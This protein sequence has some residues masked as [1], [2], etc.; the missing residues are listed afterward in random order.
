MPADDLQIETPMGNGTTDVAYSQ[1]QQ[2]RNE[3]SARTAGYAVQHEP[4][5]FKEWTK[6]LHPNT[7]AAEYDQIRKK[8][9]NEAIVPRLKPGDDQMAAWSYFK[10]KTERAPGMTPAAA[11]IWP[12]IQGLT[13]IAHAVTAPLAGIERLP[14]IRSEGRVF[15]NLN[16]KIEDAQKDIVARARREGQSV[17]P[18]VV[19]EIAGSLLPF[20]ATTEVAGGLLRV[21]SLDKIPYVS[22][23]VTGGISFGLFESA[24]AKDGDRLTAGLKGFG[25]GLAIEG[26]LGLTGK[27]LKRGFSD[28]QIDKIV[29]N[30]LSGEEVPEQ[31]LDELISTSIQQDVKTSRTEGRPQFIKEDPATKGVNVLLHDEQGRPSTVKVMPGMERS[32]VKEILNVTRNGGVVDGIIHNPNAI[33]GLQRFMRVSADEGADRYEGIKVIKTAEGQ[34]P[35]IA[36]DHELDGKATQAVSPSEVVT[37]DTHRAIPHRTEIEAGVDQ[38]RDEEGYVLSKGAKDFI[39]SDVEKLWDREIPDARKEVSAQRLSNWDLK[40]L[41]PEEWKREKQ[42]PGEDALEHVDE[43]ESV[44][45]QEI[46][47]HE[48]G[49]VGTQRWEPGLGEEQAEAS[50]EDLERA[51]QGSSSARDAEFLQR[52]KQELP[53]G[54]LR[55]QLDRAQEIKRQELGAQPENLLIPESETYELEQGQDGPRRVNLGETPRRYALKVSVGEMHEIIPGANAVVVPPGRLNPILEELGYPKQIL[56][57]KP[58]VI[59]KANA[60]RSTV[61]H[62]GLHVDKYHV[63]GAAEILQG[64]DNRAANSIAEGLGGSKVYSNNPPTWMREEAFVHAATAI[65]HNDAMALERIVRMDGTIRDVLNMVNDRATRLIDAAREGVDSAPARILQRKMEDLKLRTSNSRVWDLIDQ[66]S[67]SMGDW[68]YDPEA[69]AWKLGPKEFTTNNYP[70]LVDEVMKRNGEDGAPSHTLW[71]EAR[72]VRGPFTPQGS[73]PVKEPMSTNTPPDSK[74]SGW[75]TISGLI[76][77]MSPWVSDL[78]TRVNDAL[79]KFGKK[80]PI[81]SRFKD[82]DDA[83]RSGETWMRDNYDE[84]ANLLKGVDNKKQYAMFDTLATDP[85]HWPEMGKQLNLSEED[86]RKVDQIDKWLGKFRDETGIL[87]KNYLRDELPRLR[88]RGYTLETVYGNLKK[89][90]AQMSTFE[91]MIT[92]GKLDPKARHIGSFMDT[93]MREGFSQKFTDKPLKE[94]E[95]LVE[96][97]AKNGQYMLGN[98]RYPLLN[99][100]RYMRGIPDVTAQV[101]NKFVSDLTGFM[102]ERAKAMN[103]HLPSYA[104]LPEDFPYPKALI[105]KMLVWSYAAGLGLRA[106][107]PIRDFAQVFSTV[108]PVLGPVKFASGLKAI[109]EGGFSFA[110]E[111]GALLEKRNIGEL[112]P[113]I[114]SEIPPGA[115]TDW[116]TRLANKLLAPSRWGHNIG[117]AIGFNGE[118]KAALD[119]VRGV[120]EGRLTFD[121]LTHDHTSLWW[122]DKPVRERI[123]GQISDSGFSNHEV[124]RNIAL[125][126]LDLTLWPYRRGT[127][128]S[129]LRTGAGRI[130]G[131]FGMWP[132]NYLDFLRRGATK[133]GESPKNALY[134]TAT[135]VGANYAVTSA[136]NGIGADAGKWAWFSPSAIDMSPHAQFLV[137]L[138]MSPK[139]SPEGREARRRV[140]EY[141]LDFFPSG[142]ELRN[143]E[144]ALKSG[145]EPFNEDGTPTPMMLKVLGFKPLQEQPERDVEDEIL[146]QMGYKERRQP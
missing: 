45:L 90:K 106:A 12:Y 29:T 91:R 103:K 144:Q 18:T 7:S 71:A 48:P 65:R 115:S 39:R 2:A 24:V 110:R 54:S 117:R 66:V 32:A 37:Q 99:Y 1:A 6:G 63:P 11:K 17:A 104:Q 93:M 81:Y 34:A 38:L 113:D 114:F 21:A 56:D 131:Q 142:I 122:N 146:Y 53:S 43:V 127:Q 120:R 130:F 79:S 61:Y 28:K 73:S 4:P 60:Q 41:V 31:E 59:Y 8:Y 89:T 19:G 132:M 14:G 40:D 126:T 83:F 74:W 101:M 135:W 111:Q 44:R 33:E 134:A 15:R 96:L 141:P 143:I 47:E 67:K 100:V 57:T 64:D 27:L 46:A 50:R 86:L 97:K 85:K 55:E 5:A 9:F 124:A 72:G 51:I 20:E 133:F 92:E 119:A 30:V 10:G 138:A 118:Y 98:Q 95:K 76:R 87:V 58:T 129:V 109:A 70:E 128:P 35:S 68:W 75:T 139:D 105:N 107:I 116:I 26:A 42:L 16:D 77:P 84:A 62:E 123:Q 69:G 23:I 136:M 13:G 25:T 36:L 3:A 78:D 125:E 94:L 140:I 82:V 88:S 49:R 108:L 137:D 121:E 80:L 145:D 102:G 22:R 52:A 112:Y